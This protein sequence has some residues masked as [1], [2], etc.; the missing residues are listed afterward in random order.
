MLRENNGKNDVIELSFLKPEAWIQCYPSV[1][2]KPHLLVQAGDFP[3]LLICP[4]AA[5]H[6]WGLDSKDVAGERMGYASS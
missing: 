4:P 6:S 1:R 2:K 5:C 3:F